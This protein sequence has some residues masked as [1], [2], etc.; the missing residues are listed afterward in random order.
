MTRSQMIEKISKEKEMPAA[1]VETVLDAVCETII[2]ALARDE[3]VT[4][5][6]FGRFEMRERKTKAYVNP[7]TRQTSQLAPTKIPGFKASGLMKERA[8]KQ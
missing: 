2:G 6:G 7:K 5:A 3:K 4:I 1:Q 8:A